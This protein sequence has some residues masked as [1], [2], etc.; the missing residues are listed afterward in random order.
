FVFYSGNRK[1]RILK[2]IS[3]SYVDMVLSRKMPLGKLFAERLWRPI[4]GSSI[5]ASVDES[6]VQAKKLYEFRDTLDYSNL[7]IRVSDRRC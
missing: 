2:P 3:G 6:F 1:C 4:I 5:E 7:K